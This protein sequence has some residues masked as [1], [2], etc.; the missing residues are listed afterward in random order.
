MDFKPIKPKKIYEE[1][2][3][4]IKEMIARGELNPGDKL[5]PERELADRLQVGRSAVREAYRALEAIGI[6]DI[7]PGEGTFVREIGTKSMTDIMSLAV[8]TGKDTLFELLELRKII[9][10]EASA[11]AAL[12]RT[13]EDINNMKY[14]LDKMNEDIS[15]GR[16]GDLSDLKFHYAITGAAHN[17]LLMR[18][19]NSISE[20]MK[21]EM[22]NV[23]ERLYLTPDTP[24]RLYEEHILIYQAIAKGDEK[25]AR[26]T[27]MDHLSNAEK[28]LLHN[29]SMS[30]S[31]K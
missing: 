8:V 18:L 10:T 25:E 6:I 9:E 30:M 27:M 22:K 15:K 26:H 16:L 3:D 28:A 12:R 4:Q 19:M 29:M 7:R 17:S 23:R 11:L 5:L 24:K 14:W 13:K 20:T 2:V 1:I 21:K 31:T